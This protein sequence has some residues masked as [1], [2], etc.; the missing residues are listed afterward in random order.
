MD[1][2][3]AGATLDIT[4]NFTCSPGKDAGE[5]NGERATGHLASTTILNNTN[6]PHGDIASLD[7]SLPAGL[8]DADGIAACNQFCKLHT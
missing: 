5:V 4:V 8:S 3:A 7:F 6:L 2:E 1:P